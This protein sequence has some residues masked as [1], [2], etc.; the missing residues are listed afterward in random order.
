M[1]NSAVVTYTSVSD[2]I[3]SI[4]PN[5]T[6]I[7]DQKASLLGYYAPGD[8]G[9]GDFYWD[10]GSSATVDNGV[11]FQVSGITTGRWV[12]LYNGTLNPRYYGAK[13][14]GTTDD[15]TAFNSC[16]AN[17]Y[18]SGIYVPDGNYIV[19]NLSIANK[20]LNV[21][22]TGGAV[23][24][25]KAGSASSAKILTISKQYTQI[26]GGV[27][28][29][30]KVNQT[31]TTSCIVI[32][33]D[34]V[35]I[36]NAEIKNSKQYGIVGSN[37]RPVILN[38]Y[39][40]DTDYIAL[41]LTPG[42]ANIEGGLVQGNLIDRTSSG[43]SIVE[44]GLKVRGSNSPVYTAV[45][46]RVVDNVVKMP[47]SPT[48]ATAIAI[49]V[50][51]N[52]H[53]STVSN[54]TTYGGAIGISMSGALNCAITA[55]TIE[56]ANTYG[57]ELAASYNTATGNTILGNLITQ[58]GI[59]VDFGS[60]CAVSSNTIQDVTTNGIYVY[61]NI[62]F[63]SIIGNTVTF[64]S[65]SASN[66]FAIN[67]DQNTKFIN[68]TGNSLSGGSIAKVGIAINN[69]SDFIISSN[70]FDSFTSTAISWF[71]SGTTTPG[72]IIDAYAISNNIF[73]S[74][75]NILVYN[76]AMGTTTTLGNNIVLFGNIGIGNYLD[77][78]NEV[79]FTAGSGSPVSAVTASV[80]AVFLRENGGAATT[81]YVKES[82]TNTNTGW[83][84]K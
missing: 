13:G 74:I 19:Q 25:L 82:G 55:N 50:F 63:A 41:F 16:F 81:L 18:A 40:H 53:H 5:P 43:T 6:L 57:I 33:A 12:R 32:G 68:I 34:D 76:T 2:M 54:N 42:S 26:N 49:E 59:A 79:L 51:G 8:G 48:D 11:I 39:I 27:F 46:W 7:L 70:T 69:C 14:D 58:K 31:N 30:N 72:Y 9:G 22:L 83:V 29:G 64:T 47:V 4:P 45:R 75:P 17:V 67:I 66:P 60:Y 52:A 23:L 21:N 80:G 38:N 24:T 71:G 84:G 56:S 78:K 15:T 20:A 10:S 44:G 37:N 61:Q 65:A 77:W 36:K 1:A 62:V 73:S 35:T 3:T 28:D